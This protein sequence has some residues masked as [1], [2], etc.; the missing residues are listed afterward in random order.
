MAAART[1]FVAQGISGTTLGEITAAAGVSKGLFYLYFSSKEDLVL[2]MKEQ[3][4]SKF[5]TDM[6]RA[7]S[8]ADEWAAKLDASVEVLFDDF[9]A[10]NE[11]HVVLFHHEDPEAPAGLTEGNRAVV[12]LRELLEEGTAAGAY[13]VEDPETTAILLFHAIHAF[14]PEPHGY[15]VPGDDAILRAAKHLFRRVAGVKTEDRA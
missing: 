6:Q 3:F 10:L 9:R 5:A 7:I 2:A 4:S 12:V 11:L 14:D 15:L 8:D 13:R 1:L